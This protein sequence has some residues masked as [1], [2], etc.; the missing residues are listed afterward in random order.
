MTFK[1]DRHPNIILIVIDALRARNLGCYGRGNGYSPNIDKAARAGILFEEAYSAWNTTDQSLTSILTGRYPRTHGIMHHG[2]K[3]EPRDRERFDSIGVKTLAELLKERDYHTMA[4]DW[5]ARWFTR[6][7]DYYGYEKERSL[8]AGILYNLFKLPY[9][10]IKYVISNISLLRLYSRKRKF[11]FRSAWEGCSG[12]LKTFRFTFELARIQDAGFVTDL[13]LDLI[14]KSKNHPFFLLL[15]YWDTHTPYN[16]PRRFRP[17]QK[18]KPSDLKQHLIDVYEGAV[19]YVDFHI[20]RLIEHLEKEG[21]LNNTWIII[22]SDHGESLTEHDIF[23]DHHGL[24]DVTTHCPLVFH[25][26]DGFTSPRRIKGFVQHIDLVPTICD[27]MNIPS[28]H[29]GF[30][31]ASLLPAVHGGETRMRDSVFFEE[32]YV[33]RKIGLREDRF[34]YIYAP[35]GKGWCKYCE[36]VHKGVE[37]LYDLEKDPGETINLMA[38]HP[39]KA[40]QLRRKLDDM[41]LHLNTKRQKEFIR[42]KIDGL[43]KTQPQA[44]LPEGKHVLM[45][46]Q[47]R[48][49]PKLKSLHIQLP[50]SLVDSLEKM[51]ENTEFE[52]K[53]EFVSFLVQEVIKAQTISESSAEDKKL[54][55][56]LRSLGYMD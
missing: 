16:A 9:I 48:K 31:G 20:G 11:S 42:G 14:K 23:F 24:Y 52:G 49:T 17:K 35:D 34:K 54:K 4:V 25:F 37:E 38:R 10:H 33:Q 22:T 5:M 41:I 32:S 8:P 26:P 19:K 40:A 2:D 56:K 6:G 50:E 53:E 21:R 3:V 13:G 29:F 51:T 12:V 44:I 39:E 1:A 47:K 27:W 28:N 36:K 45:S 18:N 43:K 15:H 55:K 7:F 46:E 30:D